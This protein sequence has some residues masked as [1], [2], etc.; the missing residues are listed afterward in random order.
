MA[1][2]TRICK[3]CGKEYP[4][5]KTE[6]VPGSFRY[7]DVACCAEHGQEYLAKIVESR[8]EK[9]TE[10]APKTETVVK[11]TKSTKSV[12]NKAKKSATKVAE[13]DSK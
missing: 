12:E 6:F 4:F 2:N 1:N 5:C 9:K 13:D 10:P 8:T 7:Q 3:I 11:T